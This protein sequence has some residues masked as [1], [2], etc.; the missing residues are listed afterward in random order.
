MPA[1]LTTSQILIGLNVGV[2]LLWNALASDTAGP[3]PLALYLPGNENFRAWQYL[4]SMFMHGSLSHLLMNMFGLYMF[5]SVLERMWGAKRFL[6]FYLATGLGA[7]LI[8]SAVTSWELEVALQPLVEIGV[9][10]E[11]LHAALAQPDPR[12]YLSAITQSNPEALLH[13]ASPDPLLEPWWIF[14]V[15]VVGASGALYGI[16]TAFGLLF[17]NAK[18][19]LIFLPV[20]VAAKFFIPGL[21]LLDLFSGLTGFSLFGGGIAHFAHLGGAL[22]GFLLMRHWR[23]LAV[24]V[25]PWRGA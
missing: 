12:M 6:I 8:F 19:A 15:P 25:I 21:L 16:L 20:P 7:G 4:T 17:P 14:H 10:P 9:R 1:S 22:I 24:P 13:V 11:T 18:L 3:G 2:Y 23:D 5:G